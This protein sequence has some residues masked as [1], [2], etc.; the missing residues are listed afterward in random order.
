MSPLPLNAQDRPAVTTTAAAHAD[1]EKPYQNGNQDSVHAAVK[2][3]NATVPDI[4]RE[5]GLAEQTVRNAIKRLQDSGDIRR[6]TWGGY[7]A[8]TKQ[9]LLE[10]AWK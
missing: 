1:I 4:M 10:E 3:G 7:E 6:K 2:A 9:C 5:T 8:T